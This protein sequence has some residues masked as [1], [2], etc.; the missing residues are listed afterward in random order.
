MKCRNVKGHFFVPKIAEKIKLQGSLYN[1]LIGNRYTLRRSKLTAF[2]LVKYRP[3]FLP[4]F[5]Y[6][7]PFFCCRFVFIH[8]IRH[9]LK[10]VFTCSLSD[11][12]IYSRL[13]VSQM[14]GFA[15]IGIET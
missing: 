15:I 11:M 3:P 13:D 1:V 7:P 10:I 6:K 14:S 4:V 5:Y 12:F 2:A 9:Y 8:K